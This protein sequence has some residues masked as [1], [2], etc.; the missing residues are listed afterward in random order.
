MARGS[1]QQPR[2]GRRSKDLRAA[3]WTG[4]MSCVGTREMSAFKKQMHAADTGR[5]RCL[6][7]RQDRCL[8]RQGRCKIV[9]Q[10]SALPYQ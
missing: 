8:L 7:L 5:D 2:V 6:L 10:S 1:Q 4:Q 3:V 9:R